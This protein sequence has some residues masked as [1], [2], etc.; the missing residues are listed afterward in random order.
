MELKWEKYCDEYGN[1]FWKSK[2]HY[3]YYCIRQVLMNNKIVYHEGSAEELWIE[4]YAPYRE[5]WDTLE[6]AKHDM[7]M[8]YKEL[9][10]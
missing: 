1:S 5:V 8:H 3:S 7:N 6:D 10:L 4:K 2:A 9:K